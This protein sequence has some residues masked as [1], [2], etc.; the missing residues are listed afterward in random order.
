MK[1]TYRGYEIEVTVERC[2]GGWEMYYFNIYRTSDGL[3]VVED[4]SESE[5]GEDHYVKWMKERIDDFIKTKGKSEDM[6]E[7]DVVTTARLKLHYEVGLP[8]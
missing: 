1:T 2:M 4:F 3:C 7:D 6:A 5:D 8:L